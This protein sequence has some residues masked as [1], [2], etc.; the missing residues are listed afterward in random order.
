MYETEDCIQFSLETLSEIVNLCVC[1]NVCKKKKNPYHLLSFP[2]VFP[3]CQFLYL[4]S[5][6]VVKEIQINCI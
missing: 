6:V 1:L 2:Q 5:F 4:M 3:N